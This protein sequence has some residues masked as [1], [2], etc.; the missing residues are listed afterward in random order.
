MSEQEKLIKE[1]EDIYKQDQMYRTTLNYEENSNQVK[2]ILNKTNLLDKQN[3]ERVEHIIEKYGINSIPNRNESNFK[4]NLAVFLVLQ[5]ADLPIRLKY[6]DLIK[7]AVNKGRLDSS[8]LATM[9]DR[10]LVDIGEKQIYGTQLEFNNETKKYE[11]LPIKDIENLDKLRHSV[12]LEPMEKMLSDYD[13]TLN[14]IY[15]K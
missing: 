14:D 3:L 15:K 4:A 9:K 13:L 11:V 10:N 6:I 1:L 7:E 2:D 5:H 12:G 8:Y